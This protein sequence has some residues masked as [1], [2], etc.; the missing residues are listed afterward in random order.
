MDNPLLDYPGYLLRRAASS[1]LAQLSRHL[2]P[3]GLGVTEATILALI[4]RNPDISQAECGRL[5]SMQRTNLNP[6]MRRLA[7]RGLVVAAQGRGR[8]QLL[9]LTDEGS[10]LAASAVAE[11][12]AHEARI[13][14][15][16]PERLRSEL[17]PLLHCLI[18][19]E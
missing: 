13:F 15:A 16:V 8:T 17:V 18:H 10:R 5:L 1:R 12:E 14:D 6:F 2:E 11:F 4:S 19:T 7:A 9:R 3:L